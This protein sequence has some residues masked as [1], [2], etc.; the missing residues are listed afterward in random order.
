[1]SD[2]Q[3]Q[4]SEVARLLHQI[5]EEYESAQ[6]G[7]AGLAYGTSQHKIITKKMEN[8][9]KWHEELQALVGDTA[10]ALVV[11]QLESLPDRTSTSVQ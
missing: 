1:M 4:G 3:G 2:T 7:L 11:E 6:L 8:I 10:M 9:G 5:R